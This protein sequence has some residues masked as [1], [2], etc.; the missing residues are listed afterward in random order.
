MLA[1]QAAVACHGVALVNVNGSVSGNILTINGES[2]A[3]TCGCDPYHMEVEIAC[4]TSGF[5]GVAAYNSPSMTKSGCV[6]APY[7]AI[8][9]DISTLCPGTTYQW[10]ARE[11]ILGTT[12]SNP[13]GPWSPVFTFTT[14]GVM[15]PITGTASA[16]PTWV[17]YPAASTISAS[18]TGGCGSGYTYTWSHGLGTGQS[19]TV[20][21]TV[22]TN[23]T[24]TIT[25]ACSGYTVS[26]NVTV[27][28][29][30]PPVKGT[31]SANTLSVCA[32][33]SVTVTLIDWNGNIQWQSGP[34]PA[35]PYTDIAGATTNVWTISPVNS[36][37]F[38]RAKV[39]GMCSGTVFSNTLAIKVVPPPTVTVNNPTVCDGVPAT[40]TA[41][42]S[43]T[44][45]TYAWA[46]GSTTQSITVSPTVTTTYSLT[47]TLSGCPGVNASGTVTVKPKPTVSVTNPSVCQGASATITAT[48]NPGGGTYLWSTGQTTASI[49]VAPAATTTYKVIY[50]SNGCNSDTATS[51]VTIKPIPQVTVNSATI[52]NGETATLT[53]TPNLPGGTYSWSPGGST[54]QSITVNPSATTTYT[55]IY[56]LNGCIAPSA[57]GTV[58]VKP[59]STLSVQGATICAGAS[60]TLTATPSIAGGAYTWSGG[61]TTQSIIVTPAVTTTYTVS[62]TVTG[63]PAVNATATVTVNPKP[64]VTSTNATTC[65]GDQTTLT[66]TGAPAGGTYQWASGQNTASITVSPTQTTI[67]KVGYTLNG[68]KS[69][70]AYSTVTVKPRPVV[71]V[72]NA[73]M[74]NGTSATLTATP[75]LAGGTYSWSPGGSTS[76]SI[77]VNPA[78]TTT[79]TVIYTLNGCAST[80]ATGTVTVTPAPTVAIP[81]ATICAGE[82]ANLIATPTIT[83]GTYSWSNGG[84]TQTIS[85][86]P[87][88]TTSYTV[89]YTLGTCPVVTASVTVTVN[90]KPTVTSTNATICPG[91]PAT[92]TATGA[93]AGGTYLWASGQNTASITITPAQTTIYKVVYTLN[94]CNSDTSYSTVTVKPQPSVIV[95]SPSICDGESAV[96]NAAP[97]V[98]GGTFLWNP[99]GSTTQ[100]ITVTPAQT[101]TYTVTYT[102]DGCVATST[103]TVTVKP[104][105]SITIQDIAICAGDAGTL[106]AVPDI[107]GGTT[108][109][110]TGFTGDSLT[111]SPAASTTYTATYTLAG[112][113]SAPA[114]A[115]ITVNPVPVVSSTSATICVGDTATLTAAADIPGGT[116]S[117]TPGNETTSTIRVSPSTT[118]TY[119]VS[120]TVNG[121]TSSATGAVVV[122]SIPGISAGDD[123][124][125]CHGSSATLTAS[126]A[127]NYQWSTG[128]TGASI[129]VS[130]LVT[131][132]YILTGTTAACG[133]KDTVT[134]IV[135]QPI[136][137]SPVVTDLTC[138]GVCS[139][140][141]S[142]TA[143]GGIGTYLYQWP[144]GI[145]SSQDTATLC[146]GFYEVA[147]LDSIQCRGSVTVE[148]TEPAPVTATVQTINATCNGDCDGQAEVIPGG[149]T[150]P[151]TYSWSNG[152]AS[153][154][155]VNLCAGSYTMV[156][157]DNNQCPVNATAIISEP[158]PVVAAITGNTVLCIGASGILTADAVGGYGSGYSCLWS[159][160][161]TT[162][163]IT[164][165]PV[166]DTQYSLV[167]TNGNGCESNPVTVTV[168]V[169]D[170]LHVTLTP[171]ANICG[172]QQSMLTVSA[173]GGDGNY[174]FLWQ[175][176][177]LTSASINVSPYDT[178]VY[179]VTV[180]DQCGTPQV[181]DSVKVN[182]VPSPVAAFTS[183]DVF[184]CAGGCITFT[185]ASTTDSGTIDEMTWS[186]SGGAG[187]TYSGEA[188]Q[189]CFDLP[190]KFSVTLI[191]RTDLGC[192]DTLTMTDYITSGNIPTA[193]FVFTPEKPTTLRPTVEFQDRSSGAAEWVWD[194]GDESPL[195]LLPDNQHTYPGIPADYCVKLVVKSEYGCVDSI[196]KCLKVEE[197]R[198]V[199]I[200]NA[201]TPNTDGLNEEFFVYA[202][203]WELESYSLKVFTRWGNMIFESS[204]PNKGWN[205]IGPGGQPCPMDIYVYVV[206]ISD[207]NGLTKEYR[208]HVSL[209]R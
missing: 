118:T 168:Q 107:T 105:P 120:Y 135:S 57:T 167:V 153:N 130:P 1:C 29:M 15:T 170:S 131:T 154:V 126:G 150:A 159:T 200:P 162:R 98:S 111:V 56:T 81:P 71:T 128:E 26:E 178:T 46:N 133:G 202:S 11:R 25:D 70:T 33:G 89:S 64:T 18:A 124:A 88:A 125:I 115:T 203:G 161:D 83:G 34:G 138:N 169:R 114:S 43:T 166:N 28:V 96:L 99:V 85:V 101:T 209:I 62:Y 86:N 5:T 6:Q 190:G 60:A 67:Y 183:S 21:P 4:V 31:A 80:P 12:T 13:E 35:G 76:Q 74:C 198:S 171:E 110:N 208:S 73:A 63:C 91:E 196:T 206:R 78:A 16:L 44:G 20:N 19:K 42:P 95:N 195:S 27:T 32:G 204:D 93:P 113:E 39:T 37:I 163:S 191:V 92:V 109:W 23:Y 3:E 127:T 112:C 137:I 207:K 8:L 189:K 49:A 50:T 188:V 180:N 194:F 175:P 197:E 90:P 79:Y 72:S 47:Y 201:F 103:A 104:V 40:L 151:Y 121:C 77:T 52:C 108:V 193:D 2:D 61:E 69:D 66:A 145:S 142:V 106:A 119:T 140:A 160:G 146:A 45:G 185:D 123:Q 164:V 68:C 134:V 117:W 129:T 158:A 54:A 184:V 55:V 9:I 199:Y 141:I 82:A 58:T 143:T 10:R 122:N 144:T 75:S 176:G 165:S 7:P 97:S 102:L 149:G 17:C 192:R 41:T 172:G 155:A 157:T 132:S 48:G 136:V 100:Q 179:T 148:V 84:T 174:S 187:N 22:T 38:V 156:V 177:A 36:T 14:P 24:V 181:S 51:T 53:A 182:V 152:Q 139:G 94:G 59:L 205:G 87:A 186:F 30:E 116:F 65:P 147:V 173:T